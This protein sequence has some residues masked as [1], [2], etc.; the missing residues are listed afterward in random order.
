MAILKVAQMGN[1]ILRKVAEPVD[2][3]MIANP[4]FQ[5]F[6]DDLLDTMDEYEGAGLAAPQV[7]APVRVAVITLDDERGPE[8]FINPVVTPLTDELMRYY[9]GCLSVEGIRAAVDRPSKV[10]VEALDRDGSPKA[11]ELEGFPAIVV[12]HEFDHLDG[13][14]YVDRCDTTTMAFMREYRRFGPLD[15]D[16]DGDLEEGEEIA[17]DETEF[18]GEEV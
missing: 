10:R 13:I 5:Q 16:A 9:E 17:D 3:A 12:Q 7:H 14:L 6:L 15:A 8:F 11:Y 18:A 4:E 1:P 2:P